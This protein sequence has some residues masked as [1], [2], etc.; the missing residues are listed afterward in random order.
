V[1]YKDNHRIINLIICNYRT[2]SQKITAHANG[3]NHY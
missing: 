2:S 1:E 3:E